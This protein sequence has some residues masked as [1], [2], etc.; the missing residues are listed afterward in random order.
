[1]Q[2]IVIDDLPFLPLFQRVTPMV[3][4]ANLQNFRPTPTTTPETWNIY[5]WAIA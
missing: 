2:K 1:M 3:A 5:E 4:R